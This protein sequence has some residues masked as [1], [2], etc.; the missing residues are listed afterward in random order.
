MTTPTDSTITSKI[1]TD[2]AWLK[3][4]LILLA[5]VGVLI[6]GGIYGVESLQA[7]HDHE[8]FL[9]NQ[10]LLQTVVQ[11]NQITQQESKARIDSLAQ[12]NAAVLQQLATLEASIAARDAQ[13]FK[14]REQV[15]TLPPVQLSAKWGEAAKEPAPPIDANGNFVAPLPLVQ[16]SVD[17]LITLPVLTQDNADLK[18]QVQDQTTIATNNDLK[19]QSEVKAHTSDNNTCKAT[20]ETKNSEIKDLKASARKR[21]IIIAVVSA[22][23]GYVAHH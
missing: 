14:D 15:K 22:I 10:A 5:I 9:Q 8:Q 21:E 17:A 18:K 16:K 2:L 20:V 3:G 7:K 23:F 13:L 4:H 6:L 19:F 12:Q 1:T 11:Q